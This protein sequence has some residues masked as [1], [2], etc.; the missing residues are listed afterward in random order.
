[1]TQKCNMSEYLLIILNV[2]LIFINTELIV[3]VLHI[4]S[5]SAKQME[6][7]GQYYNLLLNTMAFVEIA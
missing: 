2:F 4:I 3:I 1:M 5:T 7:K 6:R